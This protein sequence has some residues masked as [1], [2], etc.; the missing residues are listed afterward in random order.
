MPGIWQLPPFSTHSCLNWGIYSS[1]WSLSKRKNC[2]HLLL[3][4]SVKQK[5]FLGKRLRLIKNFSRYK[6]RNA[7]GSTQMG[8]NLTLCKFPLPL[9]RTDRSDNSHESEC[10]MP[11]FTRR[12]TCRLL[13]CS[14]P[15]IN[16]L[17]IASAG[18][19][20]TLLISAIGYRSKQKLA[21]TFG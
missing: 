2:K 10:L 1:L 12:Y 14:S 5:A 7:E 4:S 13:L 21:L 11:K 3:A 15:P 8:S 16:V 20:L 19:C 17:P 18:R 6:S 9:D